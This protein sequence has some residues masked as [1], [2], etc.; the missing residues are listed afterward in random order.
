MLRHTESSVSVKIGQLN[1]GR[2]FVP[3]QPA[4]HARIRMYPAPYP[5]ALPMSTP[6]SILFCVYSWSANEASLSGCGRDIEL[7][8][9]MSDHDDHHDDHHDDRDRI[10][11]LA[12]DMTK[13]TTAAPPE[14]KSD[15][16]PMLQ[17][18]RRGHRRK[19][20]CPAECVDSRAEDSIRQRAVRR[21]EGA[22][23]EANMVHCRNHTTIKL[24]SG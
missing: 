14:K 3:L 17:V 9:I 23:R 22:E 5:G 2:L 8:V 15:D 4:T 13:R 21:E 20:R 24:R 10:T 11:S 12:D 16:S 18:S 6:F 1:L 7:V 19:T